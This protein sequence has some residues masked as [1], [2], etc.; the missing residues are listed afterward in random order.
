MAFFAHIIDMAVNI[1]GLNHLVLAVLQ[2]K[3]KKFFNEI[4]PSSPAS[5]TFVMLKYIILFV[6]QFKMLKM[7]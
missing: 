2:E 4:F 7:K 3:R 6:G 1:F 5:K